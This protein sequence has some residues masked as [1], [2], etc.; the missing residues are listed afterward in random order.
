[1]GNNKNLVF[2]FFNL[3]VAPPPPLTKTPKQNKKMIFKWNDG[4]DFVGGESDLIIFFFFSHRRRLRFGF[5]RHAFLFIF[6]VNWRLLNASF[7]CCVFSY[8]DVVRHTIAAACV[9][10]LR[11]VWLTQRVPL[12]FKWYLYQISDM[13]NVSDN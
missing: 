1:V 8:I 7:A 9:N 10:N 13:N 12:V 5:C 3:N 4:H 6:K 11:D 2:F